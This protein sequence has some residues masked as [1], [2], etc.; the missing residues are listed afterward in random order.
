MSGLQD[1]KLQMGQTAALYLTGSTTG[2]LATEGEKIGERTC[3]LSDHLS[4]IG[5]PSGCTFLGQSPSTSN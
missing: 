5:I 4:I 3:S 1:Y 2:D